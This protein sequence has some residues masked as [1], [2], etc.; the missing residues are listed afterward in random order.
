MKKDR[1]DRKTCFLVLMLGTLCQK[2]KISAAVKGIVT[3]FP[4]PNVTHNKDF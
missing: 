1:E 4:K 3:T 2:D